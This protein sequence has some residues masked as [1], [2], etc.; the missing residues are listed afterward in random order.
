MDSSLTIQEKIINS[1]GQRHISCEKMERLLAELS[2]LRSKYNHTVFE[3][4]KLKE[5]VKSLQL[6]KVSFLEKIAS[7]E[8]E[9]SQ[10]C[11]TIQTNENIVENI[12]SLETTLSE[13]KVKADTD[14]NKQFG[15]VAYLRSNRKE[16]SVYE[17]EQILNHKNKKSKRLFLVRWKG[18]GPDEDTW[19]PE[20]NLCCPEILN[21][22]LE[23]H[24][25]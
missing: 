7:L 23:N 9:K 25:I 4:E 3:F 15:V 21:A 10:K 16:E 6:E 8:Q 20:P 12:D 5:T 17:V 22:Y 18:Y 24:K 19:E 2:S 1:I 11:T 14:Q 13:L